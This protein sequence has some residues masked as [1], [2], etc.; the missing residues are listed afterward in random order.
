MLFTYYWK[1][2]SDLCDKVIG[3]LN[4]NVQKLI[5]IDDTGK[6]KYTLIRQNI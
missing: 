5:D 2:N 3:D 1:K 6:T 4:F